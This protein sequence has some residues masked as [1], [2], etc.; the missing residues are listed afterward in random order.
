LNCTVPIEGDISQLATVVVEGN[1]AVNPRGVGW[2]FCTTEGEMRA[3][4]R[5]ATDREGGKREERRRHRAIGNEWK[6][7]GYT[8]CVPLKGNRFA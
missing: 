8:M 1:A 5:N 2:R 4:A 3:W 7:Q 6:E